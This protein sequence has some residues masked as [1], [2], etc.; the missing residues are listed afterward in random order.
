MVIFAVLAVMTVFAVIAIAVLAVAVRTVA[1]LAVAGCR[2]FRIIQH[3]AQKLAFIIR[4]VF[5]RIDDLFLGSMILPHHIQDPLGIA[6]Q[7][8]YIRWL[9]QGNPVGG[10]LGI[11]YM[12]KP[13]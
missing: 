11:K 3:E 6:L 9:E 4:Q 13:E 7:R 10:G 8:S 12:K 1:I 5:H 2:L